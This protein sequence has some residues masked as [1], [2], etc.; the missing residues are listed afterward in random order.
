M[1]LAV[2]DE[3]AMQRIERQAQSVLT[4]K[5]AAELLD[6]EGDALLLHVDVEH[7]HLHAV[8]L[9]EGLDSFL[10]RTDRGVDWLRWGTEAAA[11]TVLGIQAMSA[12]MCD[13]V[14]EDVAPGQGL[15]FW[16]KRAQE[17]LDEVR[18][19]L[20]DLDACFDDD[21][22]LTRLV[23]AD[24]AEIAVEA[25]LVRLHP[26]V[27][28]EFTGQVDGFGHRDE[29]GGRAEVVDAALSQQEAGEADILP[30]GGNFQWRKDGERRQW[31]P[32]AIATM[33][34][35]V[36]TIARESSWELGGSTLSF[37]RV[38][39]ELSKA[40]AANSA[41]EIPTA[42]FINWG[43]ELLTQRMCPH[44]QRKYPRADP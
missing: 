31:D 5:L 44:G 24:V 30:V 8:A 26:S 33:Q 42:G 11:A 29:R 32:H 22:H 13:D 19:S 12:A 14:P 35:A 38:P 3:D 40:S 7:L 34:Q 25:F 10:A 37:V 18:Q 36:R 16:G 23:R 1:L 43:E 27:S 6:A 15:P 17:T 4:Q 9:L 21:R 28:A 39:A 2:A 20:A 41:T